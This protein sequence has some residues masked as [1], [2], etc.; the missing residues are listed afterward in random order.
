M[1]RSESESTV[2]NDHAARRGGF[3]ITTLDDILS[4]LFICFT[5][6][7]STNSG[8]CNSNCKYV[9]HGHESMREKKR[10]GFR[11][12]VVYTVMTANLHICISVAIRTSS[13]QACPLPIKLRSQANT[14]ITK[15]RV[16]S[17]R[18]GST[19]VRCCERRS[20]A[21]ALARVN[22]W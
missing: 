14:I 7:C 16:R 6:C 21:C 10:C 18:Q 13:I 4:M 5:S 20:P 8:Q 3:E 2:G 1:S 9:V 15:M 19:R 17:G 11:T 12:T 22:D